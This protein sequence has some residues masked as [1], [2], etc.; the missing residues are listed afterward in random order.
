MPR[1]FRDRIFSCS[2]TPGTQSGTIPRSSPQAS[3]PVA[4]SSSGSF[5][6]AL[7]RQ[8]SLCLW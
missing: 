1:I 3:I 7:R 5:F 6:S 8:N 4:L 2:M